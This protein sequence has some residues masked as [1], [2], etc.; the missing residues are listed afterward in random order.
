MSE[1]NSLGPLG[2]EEFVLGELKVFVA[3]TGTGPAGDAL[4]TLHLGR[5]VEAE[6]VIAAKDHPV[7]LKT[8]VWI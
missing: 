8:E 1:L 2:G 3:V 7:A 5:V 6:V 4:S